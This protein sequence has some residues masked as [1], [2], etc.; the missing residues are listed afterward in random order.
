MK[1]GG[2]FTEQVDLPTGTPSRPLSF[3]DVERKFRD[4][5]A[6]AGQPI[7]AA[8]ARRLVESVARLESW[9]TFKT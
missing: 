5:L 2:V 8:N 3:A 4:C 6:H 7:S 1:D 9:K